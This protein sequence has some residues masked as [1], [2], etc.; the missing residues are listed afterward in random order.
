MVLLTLQQT[1][2][3]TDSKSTV[4]P[5]CQCFASSTDH[6]CVCLLCLSL[7]VCLTLITACSQYVWHLLQHVPSMSDT[8]YSMFT[9]CLTLI[10]AC[11]QYVW[12]LLQ[13]VPSIICSFMAGS[14]ADSLKKVSMLSEA[15]QPHTT[16]KCTT[17]SQG[18]TLSDH[19]GSTSSNRSGWCSALMLCWW[20]FHQLKKTYAPLG[21]S[22]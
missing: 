8:Y 22:E 13:H 16:Q 14:P 9:V 21:I 4:K 5:P 2:V 11:S 15:V 3:H 12:H 19:K 20:Y 1:T 18:C 7:S 10:T 6:V 17:T